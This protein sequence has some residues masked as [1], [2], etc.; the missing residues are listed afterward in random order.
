[1][2]DF[3][4]VD[5]VELHPSGGDRSL[6]TPVLTRQTVDGRNPGS[7]EGREGNPKFATALYLKSFYRLFRG[8]QSCVRG[9]ADSVRV[10]WGQ[11][12]GHAARDDC[13]S[14]RP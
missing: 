9:G 8:A 6:S 3:E 13:L 4:E 11:G 1:M 7:G 2:A 5:G 12:G 14:S 10:R